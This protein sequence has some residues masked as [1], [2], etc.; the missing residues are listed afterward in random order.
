MN[1]F[2]LAGEASGDLH[3]A[4][5]AEALSDH[6]LYGVAG[7]R[8]RAA[9]VEPIL[10]SEDFQ[11]MGFVD[12]LRALPR[13]KTQL[14]TCVDAI[15]ERQPDA[16]VT[17]DYAGFN[18]R[19][20][21]RL[22]DAGY[23]GKLIQFISPKV[24][25][26]GKGRIAKLADTLDLLLVIFPFETDVFAD[27]SLP[28]EYVGNP[29]LEELAEFTPDPNFRAAHG[30]SPTS[31]ILGIFPG[32]RKAEIKLN[33]PHQLATAKKLSSQFPD[34]EFGLSVASDT[35]APLIGTPPNIRLIRASD[36]LMHHSHAALATSGTV[37][38]QLALH[39]TPTVVVYRLTW[40][41][42]ILARLIF[43]IN[44]PHYSIANICAG[45][46]LFP[47]LIHTRF[48]PKNAARHLAP[49]VA[50]GP[51]RTQCLTGC[52][53]LATALQAPNASIR[54]AELITRSTYGRATAN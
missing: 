17:I 28:V 27:T 51:T 3:G 48:T 15:L 37:N 46:T 32:S 42:A 29:L 39:Q 31:P 36:Q 8:M 54:A 6:T 38:L 26:W 41:N 44:L 49:L 53:A 34:L 9:G 5:L 18:M 23:E 50:D 19:L 1:I 24:W 45:K 35:V 14:Q 33:L 43:R 21:R 13:L 47:E 22:R 11:I 52:A 25:A 4:R 30:F 20:H 16:V 10:Q 12:V 7:P 2:L 40:L